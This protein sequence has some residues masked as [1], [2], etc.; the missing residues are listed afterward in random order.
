MS[1]VAPHPP[2]PR[3]ILVVDDESQV[4]D[5]IRRLLQFDGHTVV[6]ATGGAE[7]LTL[8]PQSPFDLVA[9][10]YEM[11]GL[12]GDQLAVAIKTLR[13]ALPVL[14]ISAHGE[15]LR[16]AE[17]PLAAVDAILSKPFEIEELRAAI[18][19]LTA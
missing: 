13:P 18:T 15:Q 8:V 17:H 9:T 4:R 5:S 12:R 19:R 3:R 6:T 10:D 7:A 1:P 14:M 16:T 2:V 11:P